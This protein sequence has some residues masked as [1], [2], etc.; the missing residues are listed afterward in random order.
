[1]VLAAAL[2]PI[3]SVVPAA[4]MTL[5]VEA[6]DGLPG[7]HRVDLQRYLA[8]HMAE[9]G[10]GEWLF[11][12][13]ADGDSARDRVELTGATFYTNGYWISGEGLSRNAVGLIPPAGLDRVPDTSVAPR[14]TPAS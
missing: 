14:A 9:A 4:A 1:L 11:E 6:S 7:F 13:A 12:P 2:V 10:L 5:Q 8:L 3:A